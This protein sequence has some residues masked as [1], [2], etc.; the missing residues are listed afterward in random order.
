MTTRSAPASPLEIIGFASDDDGLRRALRVRPRRRRDATRPTAAPDEE[1]DHDLHRRA[2]TRSACASPTTTARPPRA[3]GRSNVFVGDLYGWP[4]IAPLFDGDTATG[5]PADLGVE[6]YGGGP[7]DSGLGPRR[8]RAVRRRHLDP[9]RRRTSRA[10]RTSRTRSP[11]PASTGSAPRPRTVAGTPWSLMQTLTVRGRR[12]GRHH[13]AR[14]AVDV[15]ARRRRDQFIVRAPGG[16]RTDVRP[17]RRRGLRRHG[18]GVR[19]RPQA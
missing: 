6:I 13:G 17:R 11:R 2:P 3:G 1:R 5:V 16:S 15:R 7:Y 10:S 18:A 19:R 14:T 8:R 12:P 9:A 4:T